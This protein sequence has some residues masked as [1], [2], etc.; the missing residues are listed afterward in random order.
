M[1][2]NNFIPRKFEDQSK[3]F[4]EFIHDYNISIILGETGSGKTYL[5]KNYHKRHQQSSRYIELVALDYEEPI[6][7][8]TE[9]VLLDSIDEALYHN[10]SD[11]VLKKKLSNYILKCRE[12]NE[13]VK[14]VIA[15]RYGEWKKL[16]E[17]E[18][19]RINPTQPQQLK[20]S[21]EQELKLWKKENSTKA[22]LA[23]TEN[24]Q[25]QELENK[26]KDRSV[27]CY[28]FDVLSEKD[29]EN[30]LL[31]KRVDREAFG[32]N[33]F[34]IIYNIQITL[35]LMDNFQYY[36]NQE[37]KYYEFYHHLIEEHLL[38][39]TDNERKALLN[40]LSSEEMMNI[41]S[42]IAYY[43]VKS[44]KEFIVIGKNHKLVDELSKEF[45]DSMLNIEKL[46]IILDTALFKNINESISFNINP[47]MVSYLVAYFINKN[48]IDYIQTCIHEQ[49]II[50]RF[51]DTF[52]HLTHLDLEL[53]SKIFEIN[54]FILRQHFHLNKEE[55]EK[56]LQAILF[57]F[58]NNSYLLDAHKKDYLK[59]NSL[60]K[61]DKIDNLEKFLK[62]KIDIKK[63]DKELYHYILFVIKINCTEI[64]TDSIL[65]YFWKKIYKEKGKI[66]CKEIL[67]YQFDTNNFHHNKKLFSFL[68]E[69]ELFDNAI[70][71]NSLEFKLLEFFLD[72]SE[73]IEDKD[74]LLLM[75]YLPKKELEYIS[76]AVKL[77][78]DDILRWLKYIETDLDNKEINLNIINLFIF[79]LLRDYKSQAT[80][81]YILMLLEKG[82]KDLSAIK[83][84]F[85][86]TKTK[87][88]SFFYLNYEKFLPNLFELYFT[89]ETLST[90]P[91]LYIL[92][93][94]DD[95]IKKV[96]DIY[97]VEEYIEKYRQLLNIPKVARVLREQCSKFDIEEKKVQQKLPKIY[98][99]KFLK[100]NWGD[101]EDKFEVKPELEE[102][103]DFDINTIL[104]EFIK[105]YEEQQTSI[106][107]FIDNLKKKINPSGHVGRDRSK[108]KRK[109][110]IESNI[111]REKLKKLIFLSYSNS[112]EE[113][114]IRN[115][116]FE[117]SSLWQ[118]FNK[119]DLEE[120]SSSD[121]D[122]VVTEAKRRLAN[123]YNDENKEIETIYKE[124]IKNDKI[125]TRPFII[126]EGK[127]DWKHL[128]KALKRFNAK[129][130]YL[131]IKVDEKFR[132]YEYD[133][134]IKNPNK[135]KPILFENIETGKTDMGDNRLDK[136][137]DLFIQ[138]EYPKKTIFIFDRDNED[139]VE[140]HGVNTFNKNGNIY[141]FCIPEIQDSESQRELDYICIEF[142]YKEEE[143]TKFYN[144]KRL[145]FANEFN[146]IE[147]KNRS[148]EC[149]K[150]LSRDGKFKTKKSKLEND[151]EKKKRGKKNIK[152]I[153][154]QKRPELIIHPFDVY[155]ID[156]ECKIENSLLL[157]KNDFV[158]NVVDELN[159]DNFKKIFDIIEKII[160]D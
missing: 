159:I 149:D 155:H 125:D 113:A 117:I 12:I 42:L 124:I 133:T 135:G 10:P 83:E 112:N 160:K 71:I 91:L 96:L 7:E 50:E 21:I 25:R 94:N 28:D 148:S 90:Y 20:E 56:L 108:D 64:Q 70:D 24:T 152:D 4:D 60:T 97:P 26:Y 147:N 99:T 65:L 5:F 62:E 150:Y 53:F 134:P 129:G 63:L 52:V 47:F 102:E 51:K 46:K 116:E 16:Y 106:E 126:T 77:N 100:S 78:L 157:S 156:S 127:T 139:F 154:E 17:D 72:S 119:E 101:D 68:K 137:H 58:Q 80:F 141:S 132:F 14:F 98:S 2:N 18:F 30:I 1:N 11:K 75:N 3:D 69:H 85:W 109:K 9:V 86:K 104:D 15:C 38:C 136:L 110:Y 87:S 55:Q 76:I 31:E 122:R 22:G 145:F 121:N 8:T 45:N 32:L 81:K 33:N 88:H 84:F 39:S 142:Y 67:I 130:E 40:K 13:K 95:D 27:K 128:K 23:G 43:M 49:D 118:Y 37:L 79:V 151:Q 19:R 59:E 6:D 153:V 158:E 92:E 89:N 73:K 54:P 61:F 34:E 114:F 143:L 48:G 44:D 57:T 35:Q 115:N 41:V 140:K 111:N 93:L 131:D 120:L 146:E 107:N 144:G 29:L 123:I 103:I 138:M 74:F 105:E 66:E 82:L 36:Q